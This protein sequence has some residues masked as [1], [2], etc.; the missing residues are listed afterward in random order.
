[1]SMV[2]GFPCTPDTEWITQELNSFLCLSLI[3]PD[4]VL[5]WFC[6]ERLPSLLFFFY[7]FDH[8]NVARH[9]IAIESISNLL[10]ASLPQVSVTSDFPILKNPLVAP[11]I[12][13][14]EQCFLVEPLCSLLHSFISDLIQP[15]WFLHSASLNSCFKGH[16]WCPRDQIKWPFSLL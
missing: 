2:S 1:M 12:S 5:M 16:W 9:I 8:V 3:L 4:K 7:P 14:L 6:L 13:F 11:S 10:F 15:A